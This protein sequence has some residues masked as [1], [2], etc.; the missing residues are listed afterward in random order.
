MVPGKP[1]RGLPAAWATL[2]FGGAC[3]VPYGEPAPAPDIPAELKLVMQNEQQFTIPEG[4]PLADVPTGTSMDDLSR[5][6]GCWGACFS[7]RDESRVERFRLTSGEWIGYSYYV[8]GR[9]T[10]TFSRLTS[11]FQLVE[12]SGITLTSSI[13]AY[14]YNY[15]SGRALSYE[16]PATG[17][18]IRVS[19]SGDYLKTEELT[20]GWRGEVSVVRVF[21]RMECAD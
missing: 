15:G 12:Q 4:N 16:D 5:L 7:E 8:D 6:D 13:E 1:M 18:S 20:V 17:R 11:S 3:A 19:L 21:R 9:G 2:L 10:D 14:T